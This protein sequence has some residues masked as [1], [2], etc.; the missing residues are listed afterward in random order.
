MT[1][2]ER[3]V[4]Q[5]IRVLLYCPVSDIRSDLEAYLKD[6][7]RYPISLIDTV[8]DMHQCRRAIMDLYPNV[9][10]LADISLERGNSDELLQLSRDI[11]LDFR[12]VATIFLA[13][14]PGSDYLRSALRSGAKDVITIEQISTGLTAALGGEVERAI[15]QAF[16]FIRIK[17][18]LPDSSHRVQLAKTVCFFSGKGGV[19]KSVLASAF[20][21]ELARQDPQKYV[22]LAD[23]NL[24]F[25]DL[26]A[27]LGQQP[28]LTITNL[29]RLS[30][31]L[32]SN[33]VLEHLLEVRVGQNERIFLVAAPKTVDE[34][35]YLSN[36]DVTA[37]IAILQRFADYLIIDLP[38][39]L[40]I[41]SVAALRECNTLY[42][43]T[44]PDML[45]IRATRRF[46]DYLKT[47]RLLSTSADIKIV[48]N[49]VHNRS[50]VSLSDIKQLF[51]NNFAT[52]IPLQIEY[53]SQHVM[54]GI[55]VGSLEPTNPLAR[56]LNEWA[57]L[58]LGQ[59]AEL[60]IKQ[61]SIKHKEKD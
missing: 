52:H 2:T 56:A 59:H 22:V 50:S 54:R 3:S 38:S 35:L 58:Y 30:Q 16:E 47:Q 7:A 18:V 4:I 51:P 9:V 61:K 40:N 57:L 6:P 55:P 20:A 13:T 43:V 32:T 27:I 24:Q 23:F 5:Q 25:G 33:E 37:I 44:E 11:N 36:D 46:L 39:H 45:S 10:I 41:T 60:P 19:G 8:Q 26:A 31:E 21:V 28:H 42:L 48:L 14:N 12:N 1:T 34:L 15:M 17:G 49:K 53:V 29:A